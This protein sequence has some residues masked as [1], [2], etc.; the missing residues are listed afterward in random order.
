MTLQERQIMETQPPKDEQ[1]MV[2]YGVARKKILFV[3]RVYEFGGAERHLID[4]VRR[5]REPGL[6]ISILCIGIDQYSKR[7]DPELDITV[8]KRETM[9]GPVWAWAKFFRV[10]QPDVVV[11]IYS[12]IGIFPWIASV[13]AWLAGVPKRFSIQHLILPGQGERGL[14][15]RAVRRILGPVKSKIAA[16]SFYATICVSNELGKSLVKDFGFPPT[17]LRT[18]HNG[19]SLS[20]FAPSGGNG[21]RM[22]SKLGV[23]ADEFLLVCAAR[24]SEQKGVDILL[25]AVARVLQDGI[26]CKCVVVGDGPLREQLLKQARDLGISDRIFFEGFQEDVRPYLQA[27]SAFVLTSHRE[28]LPL[29][30]L[31][32]MA[33]GLPCIVTDVGGNAEAVIHQI[34]GLIV[35]PGSVDSVAAAISYMA[36]HPFERAEMSRMARAAAHE[37]FD[38]ENTMAAIKQV[39]L[40]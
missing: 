11:F 40:N 4:L 3:T 25:S 27:A 16:N 7:L 24:L 8:I 19:V 15:R 29:A 17:K 32:A 23:R 13:G 35:R 5:L 10:A 18:I 37:S 30:I 33:C 26:S 28:G 36:T 34:N 21:V 9:P 31:E 1:R 2:S 38:I 39:I 14:I 6:E 20:E 12:W 22:R